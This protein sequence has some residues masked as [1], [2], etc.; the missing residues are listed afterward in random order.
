MDGTAVKNTEITEAPVY[1]NTPIPEG[2][3]YAI[4][5][6]VEPKISQQGNPYF[7]ITLKIVPEDTECA[8]RKHWDIVSLDQ[9]KNFCL[10][11]QRMYLE[12]AGVAI[13][14]GRY[15]PRPLFAKTKGGYIGIRIK[16]KKEKYNGEDRIKANVI[17]YFPYGEVA[18]EEL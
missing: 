11:K 9:T 5:E 17:K 15:D 4:I 1:D 12:S 6:N 18:D 14:P 2:D 3:Y 16:H 7:N 13:P 8:N 10:Q